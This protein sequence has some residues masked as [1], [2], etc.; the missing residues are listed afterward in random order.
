MTATNHYKPEVVSHPGVTLREKLEELHMGPKEFAIRT[1]KPEKTISLILSGESAITADMAVRFES[2]L[3]IPARFWI[4]RQE[5]HNESIARI[6][7][8]EAIEQAIPWVRYFPYALM[9]RMGWVPRTRKNKEKV[10]YLFEFFG[11][12]THK[13]WEDYYL[14]SELKACFRI[15]LAH[16]R[17]P[18]AISAWLR[19]GDILVKELEATE[20][21]AENLK[22]IL[23]QL[24][25]IM[26]RHPHDF[27]Y[28]VQRLCLSVGVKVVYTPSLPKAPVNGVARW[29][30]QNKTPLI[31]ISDRYKRNDIFWFSFFHE[32]GHILLHGKKNIFLENV[33]Y[34]GLDMEKEAEADA[35]AIEWT[36]SE[37]QEK[38]I[39]QENV[40]D[41][42]I[43]IDYAKKFNTHPALIVGRLQ[44]KEVVPY[45]EGRDLIV[46]I[47]LSE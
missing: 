43:F 28:Q 33:E 32:L 38:E 39:M 40:L 4:R 12:S 22:A 41:R 27:F 36:L 7:R 3:S 8:Q 14:Y 35:F 47:D 24:K 15:S 18:Y 9:A 20:Y 42:E 1:G 13:A 19:K 23:P 16:T 21:T 45:S 31:Q 17:D 46:A 2:V 34:E 5:L 44:K 37:E 10:I 6:K 30:E 25:D 26:A 11:I 29:I